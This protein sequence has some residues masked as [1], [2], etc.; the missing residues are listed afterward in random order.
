MVYG[1]VFVIWRGYI[2]Y[3]KGGITTSGS[4]GTLVQAAQIKFTC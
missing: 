2:I 1:G 3:Y 4:G